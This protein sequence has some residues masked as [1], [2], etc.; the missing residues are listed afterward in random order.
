WVAGPISAG[1]K[2]MEARR[3]SPDDAVEAVR[4][5]AAGEITDTECAMEIKCA[6]TGES[7]EAAAEASGDLER[8]ASEVLDE[9]PG[10][11]ADYAKNEKAA[12]KAIGMVMKRTGGRFSSAEV[13]DAVKRVI[14][15]R[16]R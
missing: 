14:E 2:A 9:N 1:W 7:A 13:V 5:F 3:G 8:I 11:V 16:M 4:R 15:S 6:M 12:N 10:I